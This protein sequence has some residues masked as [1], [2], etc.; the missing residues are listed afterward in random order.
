MRLLSRMH[1]TN[2]PQHLLGMA[3]EVIL[4]I[5]NM[6]M[7]QHNTIDIC[8]DGLA[9]DCIEAQQPYDMT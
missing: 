4:V 2:T 1:C 9:L 7:R 8:N 3:R 6:L 5:A